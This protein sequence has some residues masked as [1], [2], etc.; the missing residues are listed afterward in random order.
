[1]GGVV[2]LED[3]TEGTVVDGAVESE[4][5]VAGLESDVGVVELEDGAEETVVDGIS[6]FEAAVAGSGSGAGVADVEVSAEREG[7]GTAG[8]EDGVGSAVVGGEAGLEAVVGGTVIDV[9]GTDEVIEGL[10]VGSVA[11]FGDAVGR[12]VAIGTAVLEVVAE[13]TI[14]VAAMGL[15]DAAGTTIAERAPSCWLGIPTH[16]AVGRERRIGISGCGRRGGGGL[17]HVDAGPG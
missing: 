5:A 3:E 11:G 7:D 8:L 6:G 1:M 13:E 14:A 15:K 10:A 4:D 17:V 16:D 2:E 9:S 12:T